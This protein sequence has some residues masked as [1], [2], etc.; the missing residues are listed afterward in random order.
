MSYFKSF[1][2]LHHEQWQ[3]LLKKNILWNICHFFKL[4]KQNVWRTHI[5]QSVYM[6]TKEKFQIFVV[7]FIQ[8]EI[9]ITFL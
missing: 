9:I 8:F 2:K 5:F 3:Q 4:K 7:F 6:V 1:L